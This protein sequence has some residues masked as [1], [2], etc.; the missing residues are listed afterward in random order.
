MTLTNYFQS[1]LL[2]LSLGCASHT[3]Y[4]KRIPRFTGIL[5]PATAEGERDIFDFNGDGLA[6]AIRFPK[7]EVQKD[8]DAYLIVQEFETC[9]PQI[10]TLEQRMTPAKRQI[11]SETMKYKCPHSFPVYCY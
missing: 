7:E 10:N 5:C 2:I 1:A 3:R 9:V 6:D 11:A 4:E 8:R